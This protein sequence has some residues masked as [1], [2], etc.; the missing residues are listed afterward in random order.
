MDEARTFFDML[1]PLSNDALK[2]DT[3]QKVFQIMNDKQLHSV[4]AS[5]LSQ[6]SDRGH[7]EEVTALLLDRMAKAA[8]TDA[9]ARN[10]DETAE[11]GEWNTQAHI[12]VLKH[13]K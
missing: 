10:G 9:A 12:N 11:S 5:I 2:S 7:K 8:T 13:N 1:L 4:I 3:R 6:G